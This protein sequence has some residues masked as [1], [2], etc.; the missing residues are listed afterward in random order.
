MFDYRTEMTLKSELLQWLAA[1]PPSDGTR[2]M[3][4][5]DVV[6][7]TVKNGREENQDRAIYAQFTSDRSERCFSLLAV[8]DGIGGMLDGGRCAE[9][10]IASI[11]VNLVRLNRNRNRITLVEALTLANQELR[12]EY[13]GRGGATF[14]GVFLENQSVKSVTLGDSRVYGYDINLGIKRLSLDDR[15]GDQFSKLKGLENIALDP[16]IANR[17]G[18]YLGMDGQPRPNIRLIEDTIWRNSEN[19]LLISTDGAHAIG[20]ILLTDLF[21]LN[22][23]PFEIADALTKKTFADVEADNATVICA[24][25]GKLGMTKNDSRSSFEQLRVWSVQGVFNFIFSNYA[26]KYSPVPKVLKTRERK[27][28]IVEKLPEKLVKSSVKVSPKQID[29]GK[30]AKQ[31]VTIKQLTFEP[32]QANETS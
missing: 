9:I 4:T 17:L 20:D 11:L 7:S 18:Q 22:K 29:S 21:R 12:Q 10:S 25:V 3:G 5:P 23:G 6:V 15:L 1:N 32:D 16:E 28:S 30:S 13:K 26:E 31:K 14:A 19:F 27:K 8:L 2:R 24:K